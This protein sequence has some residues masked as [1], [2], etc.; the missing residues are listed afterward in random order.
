MNLG[1]WDHQDKQDNLVE[2]EILD[3]QVIVAHQ[4]RAEDRDLLVVLEEQVSKVSVESGASEDH[5]EN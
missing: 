2:V 1:Q 4:V 5:Q 3:S